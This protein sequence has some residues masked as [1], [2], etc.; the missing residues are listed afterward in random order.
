MLVKPLH[1]FMYRTY[2]EGG[3]TFI[4]HVIFLDTVHLVMKTFKKSKVT[5]SGCSEAYFYMYFWISWVT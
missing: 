2:E 3:A 5:I 1:N 4:T